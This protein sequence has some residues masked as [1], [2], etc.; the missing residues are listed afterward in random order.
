MK[1]ITTL[2]N[3][4]A[5]QLGLILPHEHIFVD[6]SPIEAENWK[7]ADPAA[8]V[9]LMAPELER[10]RT[11]GVTALV[12]CTPVG[13]GR[14]ADIV[15]AVSEAANFPVVLPTGI[16]REPWVPLWAYEAPLE[17]IRDWMI[18]ELT[19]EIEG[20]GVQAGWIKLSAGDEEI[21]PV[22]AKILRAAAQAGKATGAVIGSHTIQGRVVKDQLDIIEEEGYTPE[23]FIWIHTQA[24]E[25]F[26][27]HLEIAC[28]GAW[29]EYDSIGSDWTPE[30]TF[31]ENI[32][33][34]LEAGYGAQL[35]LSHDRGW[36]DPS[37]PGGGEAKPFTYLSE[38]FLPK[39]RE[40][41]VDDAAIQQLTR[42]NSFQAFAR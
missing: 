41:G 35:M 19:G 39:L 32:P 12:E 30:A 20:S 16:Y 37:Q 31:L 13:V 26:D 38:V 6:L 2:G 28:R 33:R 24:E 8:A 4:R 11:V 17:Q 9:A 42:K 10:A 21:T 23:R 34:L 40:I 14:R 25:N 7:H 3:Y 15:R 36:F 18:A 5:D 29:L 27:L 1:L 22:E